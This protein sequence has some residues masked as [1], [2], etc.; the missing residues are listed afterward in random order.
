MSRRTRTDHSKRQPRAAI[1]TRVSTLAQ[2]DEGSSLDT[3]LEA[4]IKFAVENGYAVDDGQVYREVYTGTEL[5]AR[6]KLTMLRDVIR[7]REVDVLVAYAIDR[8]SRDPVHLGVL[9]S[10]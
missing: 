10:E 1:Y 6:P 3:Q 4:C 5:W 7:G 2:E 9:L 8:L